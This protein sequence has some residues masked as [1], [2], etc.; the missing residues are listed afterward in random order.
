MLLTFAAPRLGVQAG[1]LRAYQYDLTVLRALVA[2]RMVSVLTS[3][4]RGLELASIM[5]G[6]GALLAIHCQS[7]SIQ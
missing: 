1:Q 6:A 2:I 5:S 3:C 7:P 4:P